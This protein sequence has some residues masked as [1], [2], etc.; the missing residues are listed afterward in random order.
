[1]DEVDVLVVVID[2]ISDVGPTLRIHGETIWIPIPCS[3]DVV[4]SV[5]GNIL[6]AVGPRN[7]VLLLVDV[8]P[9]EFESIPSAVLFPDDLVEPAASVSCTG[10]SVC[11]RNLLAAHLSRTS[12]GNRSW[13]GLS[14]AFG[15]YD[16]WSSGDSD[17]GRHC[18]SE[19]GRA[20][21]QPHEP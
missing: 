4:I 10:E 7:G 20:K 15:F 11:A 5:S 18:R 3:A 17:W 19:Q 21:E 9:L 6:R 2:C 13:Q 1:M 16:F 14:N 8:I 12:D